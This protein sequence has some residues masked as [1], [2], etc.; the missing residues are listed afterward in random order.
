MQKK[1]RGF[2]ILSESWYADANLKNAKYIDEIMF[3]LYP[4]DGNEG[5]SGEMAMKWFDLQEGHPF[6]PRLEVFDDSWKILASFK[7]V[8]AK[9]AQVD[10]QNITPKQFAKLLTESGFRDL[11]K[12]QLPF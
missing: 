3:G 7:D 6:A 2:M 4:G 1:D 9:L 5:T 11:T 10:G 12:R 8:I